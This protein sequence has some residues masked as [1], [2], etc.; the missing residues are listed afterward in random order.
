MNHAVD[1]TVRIGLKFE[2]VLR[3]GIFNDML[4]WRGK[5]LHKLAGTFVMDDT[6]LAGQHEQDR[7]FDM[8]AAEVQVAIQ[9]GAF[10]EKAGAGVVQAER[11]LSKEL[12]PARLGGK[13][14]RIVQ[15]NWEKDSGPKK[16]APENPQALPQ[17]R[18]DPGEKAGA[19]QNQAGH[20]AGMTAHKGDGEL[21][22]P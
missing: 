20:Q 19:K 12:L 15:G 8:L 10:Q 16:P 17:R 11:V 2:R 14:R 4:V 9:A 6:I 5:A 21:A 18:P 3:L 7:H 22:A 13:E 1:K